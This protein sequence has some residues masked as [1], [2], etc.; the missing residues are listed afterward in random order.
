MKGKKIIII[1]KNTNNTCLAHLTMIAV[2]DTFQYVSC[3]QLKKNDNYFK[4]N[5]WTESRWI[6]F[7]FKATQNDAEILHSTCL[8]DWNL[9]FDIKGWSLICKRHAYILGVI[10]KLILKLIW[11]TRDWILNY[12]QNNTKFSRKEFFDLSSLPQRAVARFIANGGSIFFF[13]LRKQ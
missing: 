1:R 6:I 11:I 10:F 12:L 4:F 5:K 8:S 13:F 2:H 9:K 7:V 3:F